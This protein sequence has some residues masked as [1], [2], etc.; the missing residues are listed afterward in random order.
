MAGLKSRI[1]WV[2]SLA[3]S[4]ATYIP[5]T[6]TLAAGGEQELSPLTKV[7]FGLEEGAEELRGERKRIIA[8]LMAEARNK[9]GF[10]TTRSLAIRL[11]GEMRAAEAAESLV[12][13][14]L[15]PLLP[16]P[17]RVTIIG[18]QEA[19]KR[20]P[21]VEDAV[22]AIGSPC[23]E[24]LLERLTAIEIREF[25][26]NEAYLTKIMSGALLP[27]D[28]RKVL[29]RLLKRIEGPEAAHFLITQR[30]NREND[31]ERKKRLERARRLLAGAQ[32]AADDTPRPTAVQPVARPVPS[33]PRSGISVPVPSGGERGGRSFPALAV[34]G[35]TGLLLG[36]TAAA[37]IF[38][39][40]RA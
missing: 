36:F 25:S 39:R 4:A 9:Q 34:A 10:W 2:V 30:M 28:K 15:A 23:R 35:L 7:K 3:V 12:D 27:E 22:V 20:R 31:A 26:P 11:L 38:R 14:S 6:G 21:L 24:P 19:R 40:R 13:L 29:V 8:A 18:L 32:G 17:D 16:E 1:L 33:S 37:L 5:A